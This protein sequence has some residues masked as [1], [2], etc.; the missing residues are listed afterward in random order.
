MDYG[1]MLKRVKEGGLEFKT[2]Y[3]PE[4]VNWGK[5]GDPN[6]T[7]VSLRGLKRKKPVDVED[8]KENL[9][10]HFSVISETF[11]VRVNDGAIT[12]AD[13]HL[14]NK[15]KHVV[16]IDESIDTQGSLMVRGWIGISSQALPKEA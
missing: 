9:A 14:R 11:E 2:S 12:A 4:V 15:C 13:M 10:R 8:I 3:S 5:T 7:L 1:E 6:G 16:E